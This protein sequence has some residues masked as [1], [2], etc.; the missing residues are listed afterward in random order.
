MIREKHALGLDPKV[1]AGFPKRS[2][3][4]KKQERD[5]DSIQND[6]TLAEVFRGARLC[7][8]CQQWLGPRLAGRADNYP[9]IVGCVRTFDAP[10]DRCFDEFPACEAERRRKQKA[11]GKKYPWRHVTLQIA[12]GALNRPGVQIEPVR[13]ILSICQLRC[14]RERCAKGC[15]EN[16]I[17][18]EHRKRGLCET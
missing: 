5:R 14:V 8:R 2:C 18:A 13:N 12:Q 15:E 17:A 11:D 7:R 10:K 9:M 16:Q 3:S 4:I 6:R 1:G